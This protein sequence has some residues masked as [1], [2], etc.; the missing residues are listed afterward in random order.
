M[1]SYVD[2][3][4]WYFR[5]D[6]VAREPPATLCL[7][8][9]TTLFEQPNEPLARF[10]H[11]QVNEGLNFL[12]NTGCSN[13][14]CCFDETRLLLDKRLAGVRAIGSFFGKYMAIHCLP[15]L[16]HVARK[17]EQQPR[18]PLNSVCYM[19]WELA[20]LQDRD[21]LADACL[22]VMRDVLALPNIACQESALHGLG[23]FGVVP[24]KIQRRINRQKPQ[25]IINAYLASAKSLPPDL[26]RYA[27]WARTGYVN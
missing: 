25:A 18:N 24:G 4:A 2:S 12:I 20:C 16:S 13:H 22:E 15:E 9:L 7:E 17:V 14:F 6:Y 3:L 10:D 27:Q 11:A 21:S 19:W 23:H 1:N 5:D 26:A 8:Y